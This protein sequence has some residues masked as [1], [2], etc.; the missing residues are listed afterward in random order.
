MSKRSPSELEMAMFRVL[1]KEHTYISHITGKNLRRFL[2]LGMA[3]EAGECANF[4]KKE[5]RDRKDHTPA[6]VSELADV[7]NYAY[8]IGELIGVDV[9]HEGL[10]KLIEVEKRPEFV[11]MKKRKAAAAERQK[12]R[13]A[14]MARG[15]YRTVAPRGGSVSAFR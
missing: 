4:I 11:R 5:W 6:I 14:K 10:K 3:G 7:I 12:E 15:G 8:M 13:D 2:V 1:I 9:I